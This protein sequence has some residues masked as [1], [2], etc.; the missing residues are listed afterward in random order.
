MARG[1]PPLVNPTRALNVHLDEQQAA[2]MDLF[3][4][5]ELEGRVPKGSYQRFFNDLLRR[6]FDHQEL[7]L[8]PFIG[9][10]PGEHVI[11]GTPETLAKLSQYF[12]E[13]SCQV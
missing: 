12:K 3:L 7:D 9:A 13:Q 2:R 4:F 1:R 10:L 11:R 8:G 6:F 5:S